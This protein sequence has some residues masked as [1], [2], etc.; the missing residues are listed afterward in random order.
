V[1][2]VGLVVYALLGLTSNALVRLVE[3]RVLR[4][5]RTISP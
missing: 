3:A 2:V 1:I 4:W 5:R